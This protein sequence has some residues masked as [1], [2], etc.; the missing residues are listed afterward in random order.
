MPNLP[1]D[2]WQIEAWIMRLGS[3]PI[4]RIAYQNNSGGYRK[5]EAHIVKLENGKYATITEEG[6]SCYT[7]DRAEIQIHPNERSAKD[8]FN[9]W[10]KENPNA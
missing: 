7:A 4:E 1:F 5:A 2:D 3:F 10:V 8:L 9:K 6:C